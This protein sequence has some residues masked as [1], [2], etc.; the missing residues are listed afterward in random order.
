MQGDTCPTEC[1]ISNS[2]SVN[3]RMR[4]TS[5]DWLKVD[6]WIHGPVAVDTSHSERLLFIGH[7]LPMDHV[8]KNQLS[9]N[10]NLF[11]ACANSRNDCWTCIL[12][13]DIV[14]LCIVCI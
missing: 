9:T 13:P 5:S 12:P 11:N 14:S 1:Y 4:L 2:H 10:Q 7:L 6:F 8:S 3:L